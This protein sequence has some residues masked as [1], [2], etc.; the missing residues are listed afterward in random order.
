M[1]CPQCEHNVELT[2]NRYWK[3]PFGTHSCP[4]CSSKFKLRHSPRYHLLIVLLVIIFCL[5]PA[6]ISR[7]LG[8]ST[9]ISLI[10]LITGMLI[11]IPIDK[12]LDENWL[13]DVFFKRIDKA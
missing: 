6:I 13:G 5:A 10:F 9:N 4:Q 2:W 12:K 8:F 11:I 3:A 1:K 7:N